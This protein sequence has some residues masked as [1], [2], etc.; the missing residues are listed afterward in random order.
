MSKIKIVLMTAVVMFFA[1]SHVAFAQTETGQI[2]GKVTDPNGAV[3]SGANVGV[4]SP[5]TGRELTAVSNEEGIY[6]IT[7][8][9]PGVYD[10]TIQGQGFA[11]TTQRVQVTVGSKTSVESILSVTALSGETIQVVASGGVEVNT[12]NQELSNVVSG[13]QIRELPTITR[14]PYNLVLLSGNAVSDDPSTA[15]N[16]TAG[17]ATYRGAGA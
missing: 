12:Q 3:V 9:Q 14:N 13:T 2:I 5:D 10:V 7:N 11:P 8:L 15:S 6:T 4:K 1:L 17:S 16:N